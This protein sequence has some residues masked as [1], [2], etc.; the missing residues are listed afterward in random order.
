MRSLFR[1]LSLHRAFAALAILAAVPLATAATHAYV[2]AHGTIGAPTIVTTTS[3]ST[4]RSTV[5]SPQAFFFALNSQWST[6]ARNARMS[7]IST[8]SASGF[9]D[10][11]SGT[12][13]AN[14][15]AAVTGTQLC[16]VSLGASPWN[17]PASGSMTNAGA[18]SCS[19]TA[20]AGS[21]GTT[22]TYAVLYKSD[23]TTVLGMF[24][25]GTS[26]ANINMATTTI[27][28]GLTV[29]IAGGALTLSDPGSVSGY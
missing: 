25:V 5:A 4:T 2:E 17:A 10:F 29:N 21:G 20:G 24:S 14:A 16:S 9:L 1:S 27:S 23:H 26:G 13:P 15:D 11:Y 28:T 7:A 19:G 22:A 18:L 3:R 6:T 8:A 12:Q